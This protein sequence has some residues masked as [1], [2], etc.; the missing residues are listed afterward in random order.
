MR[1]ERRGRGR[2]LG[3]EARTTGTRSAVPGDVGFV[4]LVVGSR[5]KPSAVLRAGPRHF[6]REV[7]VDSQF[8]ALEAP[9]ADERD[10][11]SVDASAEPATR[12]STVFEAALE[13]LSGRH[14]DGTARRRRTRMRAISSSE[15]R[16][17]VDELAATEMLAPGRGECLLV[18][19]DHTRLHSRAGE[20]TGLLFERLTA[21]GCEV[22]VLPALGT[23][24]AMTPARGGPAL[25]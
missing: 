14:L 3:A 25:R 22:A 16:E 7:M 11:V 13:S 24:A 2:L 19:P 20:I 17:L 23:P 1:G 6:M 9:G 21:A 18:P 15:L 10:V 12:S 8:A 5:M 4:N